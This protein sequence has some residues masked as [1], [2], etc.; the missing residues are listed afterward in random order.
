MIASISELLFYLCFN[1]N[2]LKKRFNTKT[3]IGNHYHYVNN[4]IDYTKNVKL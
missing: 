1:L 4:K 3:F 2:T